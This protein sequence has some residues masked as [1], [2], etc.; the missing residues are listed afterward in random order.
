M[1]EPVIRDRLLDCSSGSNSHENK[2]MRSTANRT[3]SIREEEEDEG[4][5]EED[6]T[7]NANVFQV[8]EN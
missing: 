2:L 1:P 3:E 6:N 7:S 4:Q 5:H 8:G